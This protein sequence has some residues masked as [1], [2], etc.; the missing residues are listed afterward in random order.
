MQK[1]ECLGLY[2]EGETCRELTNLGGVTSSL[3]DSLSYTKISYHN[4]KTNEHSLFGEVWDTHW[5]EEFMN[6]TIYLDINHNG[7]LDEN[8][9]YVNTTTNTEFV[10]DNL[11]AGI[12]LVRQQLPDGC[13]QLYPGMNSSYGTYQGDGYVDKVSHYIHY[14]HNKYG[15]PYG[16]IIEEGE[17]H[18]EHV[19]K[20]FS[21]IIGN[22]NNT[23]LS[24][25]VN[26]SITL[27]FID[28][29]VID[30][31]GDDIF[32]DLF[33]HTNMTANVSVS[34]DDETYYLLGV[35]NT[36]DCTNLDDSHIMRQSFDL[37]DINYKNPVIYIRLDFNGTSKREVMNVIRVGAYE[38]SIYLPVIW[39]YGRGSI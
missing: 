34:S 20:N 22:Q 39:F 28:E 19:N 36:S 2:I 21:M 11:T 16:S 30:N 18:E 6:T 33:G 10:F 25:H 31:Q 37:Q 35:L 15:F 14:G 4:L 13:I 8:E 27:S 7:I 9:P 29:T 23:H 38:R 17:T 26:Y 3:N 32:I 5:E 24:F 12:Y 1:S